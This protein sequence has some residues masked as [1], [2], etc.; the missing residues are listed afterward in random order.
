LLFCKIF[1][2]KHY[3]EVVTLF[4]RVEKENI[5]NYTK[6]CY[7]LMDDLYHERDSKVYHDNTC[8]EIRDKKS[9]YL[10]ISLDANK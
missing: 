6:D 2:K 7:I 1:I 5:E 8:K 4:R 10:L 3:K 9:K